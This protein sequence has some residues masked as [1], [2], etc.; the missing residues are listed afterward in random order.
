M[1][2][3]VDVSPMTHFRRWR[4]AALLLTSFYVIVVYG[5]AIFWNNIVAQLAVESQLSEFEVHKELGDQLYIKLSSYLPMVTIIVAVGV[6]LLFTR[7][8]YR[9]IIFAIA[10]PIWSILLVASSVSLM[11]IN[12]DCRRNQ[13][14]RAYP[15]TLHLLFPSS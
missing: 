4:L 6:I 10:F 14:H 8:R 12:S 13:N 15:A 3:I 2:S 9:A 11:N 7:L 1:F 5:S